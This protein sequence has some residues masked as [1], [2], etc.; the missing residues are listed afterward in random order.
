MTTP[1]NQARYQVIAI[2]D[3]GSYVAFHGYRTA[4]LAAKAV[5]S[6]EEGIDAEEFARTWNATNASGSV[7]Y[8]IGVE[9]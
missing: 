1:L 8:E 4:L 9:S 6:V 5:A 7:R 3:T 2:D